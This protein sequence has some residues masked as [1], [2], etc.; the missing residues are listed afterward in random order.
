MG[1]PLKHTTSKPLRAMRKGN[2]AARV[3]KGNVG[4]TSVTGYYNTCSPTETGKYIVYKMLGS[5]TSPLSFCPNNDTEFINLAKQEGGNVTNVTDALQY[6]ANHSD[7]AV[8]AL[9]NTTGSLHVNPFCIY[10]SLGN[11]PQPQNE[12]FNSIATLDNM[13]EDDKEHALS[14]FIAMRNHTDVRWGAP[15]AGTIIY[16]IDPS[17]NVSTKVSATSSP[18]NGSFNVTQG[19]RYVGSKPIHIHANANGDVMCPVSYY[20]KEWG[21]F[22]SRY[23]PQTV[24]FYCFEDNTKITLYSNLNNS[25]ISNADIVTILEGDQGDVVE[26]QIPTNPDYTNKY[27]QIH[28]NEFIVM[29][30][31]G[32]AGD[33]SIG[34]LAGDRVYRRYNEYER[35]VTNTS[36]DGTSTYTV[37]DSTEKVWALSIADGSGGDNEVGL[38]LEEL[39]KNYTYGY[40]LR[41]YF[42]V[43]PYIGNTIT[44]SSWNGSSWVEFSSHTLNGTITA[45]V[46][47]S[48]GSQAGG[49]RFNS[50]TL[51]KFEGDDPFYIVIN[52]DSRDEEALLGWNSGNAD[53]FFM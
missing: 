42:V 41:S 38:P 2:L 13:T 4:P 5:G 52:D 25:A 51:W 22:Y 34:A 43:S 47:A 21:W 24:R 8:T 32:S 53:A 36:P 12:W 37:A 46:A 44:I 17:G 11:N 26:Y 18:S 49:D 1:R 35:T 45:P 48:S 15:Y 9:I 20:G 3:G 33:M 27:W 31:R 6:F 50:N 29:T 16:E 28:S 10:D 23:T 19:Y 40:Y 30:G 39:S 7:Y 14:E